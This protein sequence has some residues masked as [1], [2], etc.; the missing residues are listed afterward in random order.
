MK[1]VEGI[2]Q[3]IEQQVI[4]A[5]TEIE[6]AIEQA[7]RVLD[8]RKEELLRQV[9]TRAKQKQDALDERLHDLTKFCAEIE[10]VTRTING[11][12]HSEN[13]TDIASAH[14]FMGEKNAGDHPGMRKCRAHSSRCGQ[15]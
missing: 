6:M 10:R 9:K 7:H 4:K 12:L 5:A 1:S 11:C 13:N 8:E 15:H 14:K 3:N 2:K